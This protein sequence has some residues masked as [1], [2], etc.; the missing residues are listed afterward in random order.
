MKTIFLTLLSVLFMAIQPVTLHADHPDSLTELQKE[1]ES[2]VQKKTLRKMDGDSQKV[3]VRFLI[4]A[5]NEVVIFDTYGD[6][7][8]ACAH[9]NKVL[10]YRQVKFKDAKQLMPYQISILFVNPAEE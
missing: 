3:T 6:S 2:L 7:E 1:I 10:N 4:N 5:Q 8:K 9:V